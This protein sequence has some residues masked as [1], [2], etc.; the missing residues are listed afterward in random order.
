MRGKR[1]MPRP[2]GKST[3]TTKEDLEL[4]GDELPTITCPECDMVYTVIWNINPVFT[5]TDYCPF[6]G[7]RKK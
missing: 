3:K 2:T 7:E 6:C 5:E 1:N 4:E